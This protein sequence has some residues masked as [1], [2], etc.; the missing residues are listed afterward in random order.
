MTHKLLVINPRKRKY[1][2]LKHQKENTLS[3]ENVL[4]DFQSHQCYLKWYSMTVIKVV[5]DKESVISNYR[6]V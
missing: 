3:A 6:Y 5:D 4:G 2:T 1:K